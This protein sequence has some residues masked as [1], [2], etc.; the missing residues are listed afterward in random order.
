M[1]QRFGIAQALIGGPELV[2]VDE[3]TA[4]LDPEERN[5]FLDLLSE[6]GECAVVILSTHIVADVAVLCP[7]MA[8]LA[9]GR[10]VLE[11]ASADLIAR[12][13]GRIWSKEIARS[14]VEA[15]RARHQPIS[16]RLAGGRVVV[17]ILSDHD[18]GEGYAPEAGDLEDAYFAALSDGR[19]AR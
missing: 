16:T 10:V 18:P 17:H 3:P 14:E 4:G 13:H 6:V 9:G 2:I 5:R 8:V 19:G 15:C 7:R 11:G 12:L 1:R